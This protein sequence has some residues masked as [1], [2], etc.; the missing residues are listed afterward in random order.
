MIEEFHNPLVLQ[1]CSRSY[2]TLS[3]ADACKF[4]I[5]MK[6]RNILGLEYS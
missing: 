1:S 5:L 2:L 4:V 3:R 6:V